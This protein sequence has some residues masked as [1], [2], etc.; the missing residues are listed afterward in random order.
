MTPLSGPELA[1]VVER[2]GWTRLRVSGSHHVYGKSGVPV[3]LSIPFHGSKPLKIGLF[4][5]LL[6]SA[7]LTETDL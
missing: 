5:S 7:D 1:R 2:Y 6:K 3:R 4:Q